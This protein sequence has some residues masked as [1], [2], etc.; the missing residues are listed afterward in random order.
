MREIQ[1]RAGGLDGA[2]RSYTFYYDET[3]NDRRIYLTDQGLNVAKLK[4]FVLGGIVHEGPPR[5]LDIE[6]LRAAMKIQKGTPEI[7][8]K[9]VATGDFLELL[10]SQRLATF[11]RWIAA[12]GLMMHYHEIDPLYWSVVDIIDSILPE[13]GNRALFQYHALLKSDLAEVLRSELPATIKLFHR[14]G[15]PGLA[16]ESRRPFLNDL[17]KLCCRDNGILPSFNAMMLK[18]VLQAGRGLDSL[19]FIEGYPPNMLIDDFS[20][21]YLGRIALFKNASHILDTEPVIQAHLNEMNLTSGGK[22]VDN[23]RFVDDSKD[24]LGIQLADVVTGLIGKMHTYFTE[25]SRDEVA[26]DR[27]NLKGVELENAQLLRDLIDVSDNE[28]VAFLHHV[29]SQYDVD[30]LAVFLRV[31]ER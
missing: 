26:A 16:P 31:R 1:L 20:A 4:V 19:D 6:P 22:A 17:I 23:Y 11:L 15:Y 14:Y 29:A 9:H 8:L 5:P 21:F 12:N 25:T 7:K 27:A 10:N 18:G 28:N 3:N 30:K 13:L 24:E 2:D